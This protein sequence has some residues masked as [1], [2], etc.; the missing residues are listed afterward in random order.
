MSEEH[1]KR[2]ACVEEGDELREGG[3]SGVRSKESSLGFSLG[4]IG[5]YWSALKCVWGC[6]Q[7]D[8]INI[9]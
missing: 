7:Y 5:S 3:R 2:R 8:L 9:F 6:V 1:V 4:I